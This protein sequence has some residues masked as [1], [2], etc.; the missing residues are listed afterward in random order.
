MMGGESA[1]KAVFADLAA[2]AKTRWVA[3]LE[4][5]CRSNGFYPSLQYPPPAALG[6][7]KVFGIVYGHVGWNVMYLDTYLM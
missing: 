6:S 5:S 2:T 4:Y 3:C 1:R 7:I